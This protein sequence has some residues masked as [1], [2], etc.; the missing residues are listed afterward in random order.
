ML[1]PPVWLLQCL[2]IAQ[3]VLAVVSVAILRVLRWGEETRK[4][5]PLTR[6]VFWT[7]AGYICVSNLC[8]GLLT[9][10]LPGALLEGT[11]L[12]AAVTG[13]IALWW[14]AR[15]VIQFTYFDRS[16]APEGRIYVAAEV[17]LVVLFLV[18]TLTY[19]LAALANL[20]AIVG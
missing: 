15:I 18:L 2:G 14:A 10:I 7:Y 13:F 20:R 1:T 5:N 16:Q 4:L 12:A 6:Q 8:F 9:A 11:S 17:A 3:I 19:G